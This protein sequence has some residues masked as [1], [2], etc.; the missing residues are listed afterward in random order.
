MRNTSGGQRELDKAGLVQVS[1]LTSIVLRKA[2]GNLKGE[3]EILFPFNDNTK[4]SRAANLQ[5]ILTPAE[6]GSGALPLPLVSNAL[7]S[8]TC[9]C[10]R[11]GNLAHIC[12]S[13]AVD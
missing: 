9:P 10:C 2:A 11:A 12:H 7:W 1:V 13:R 8:D 4:S 5:F 3:Q 6:V